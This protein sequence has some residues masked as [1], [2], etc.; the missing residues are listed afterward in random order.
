M[1]DIHSNDLGELFG[2]GGGGGYGVKV[3][4]P[5]NNSY[6]H[7]PVQFVATASSNAPIIA[8]AIYVN[9]NLYWKQNVS[10]IN[11]YLTLPVGADYVVV[12]AWD[13]NQVIYKTALN[14]TVQ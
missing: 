2:A 9:N 10:S 1:R 13:Q 14:I 3:S 5:L 4:S 8:M 12:Q 11:T 6:D 7:N